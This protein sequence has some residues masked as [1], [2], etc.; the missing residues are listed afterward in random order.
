MNRR[1]LIAWIATA[2]TSM[3]LVIGSQ[4]IN[5]SPANSTTTLR[6]FAAV[7][8]TNALNDIKTQYQSANPS[9]NVV[10]TFGASGTLLS[11]IQAGAAADIFISAATDQIDVLQ[12]ATPSKLVAGSRKN[13]VKNRLVLI[14]PT[15][16][17]V[18]AGS[19]ALTSFNGLTNANITGIAI[20]DYTGT[21]PVVPAGNYAKQVLTSRGIFTTVSPKTYLA[22]NVRNVLTAVENKTLVVGGVSKTIDAGAV[23]KTDAAISTKVRVVETALTTESDP[24]VYPLGILANTTVL[25]TAQSFSTYLSGTTA[26]NIFKNTYGFILP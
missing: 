22:S 19:A 20:G 13:I 8:L 3:M 5:L 24:I 7:S 26:Q 9:V 2:V 21:P 14:A 4:F 12:N 11:Q 18:S 6:V 17:P 1:R 23:Y 15:T 10:Y 25:S 16:P